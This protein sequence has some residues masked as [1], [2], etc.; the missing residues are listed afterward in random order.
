MLSSQ[1]SE[2]A[3]RSLCRAGIHLQHLLIEA[4]VVLLESQRLQRPFFSIHAVC[5]F[6]VIHHIPVVKIGVG[7]GNHIIVNPLHVERHISGFAVDFQT[8]IAVFAACNLR[9]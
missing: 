2:K 8:E 7:N 3:L 9:E 4:Q 5:D 6:R 1:V